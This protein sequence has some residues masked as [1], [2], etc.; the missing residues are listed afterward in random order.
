MT[1]NLHTLEYNYVETVNEIRHEY[2]LKTYDNEWADL[3]VTLSQIQ[4]TLRELIISLA[5]HFRYE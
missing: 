5:Y 2:T 4:E 3:T 1:P